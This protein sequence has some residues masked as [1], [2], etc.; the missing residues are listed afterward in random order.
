MNVVREPKS[1]DIPLRETINFL[2]F[3]S[4]LIPLF[5]Q[6]S[7]HIQYVI[8]PRNSHPDTDAFARFYRVF[9]NGRFHRRQLSDITPAFSKTSVLWISVYIA[10]NITEKQNFVLEEESVEF[11]FKVK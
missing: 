5:L 6:I 2:N 9:K 3:V 4:F 8:R 1:L 7:N 10:L 11:I